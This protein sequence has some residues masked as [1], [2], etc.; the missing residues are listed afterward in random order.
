MFRNYNKF[1][2]M[3]FLLL[4]ILS[5]HSCAKNN[6]KGADTVNSI[7]STKSNPI[8]TTKAPM[9]LSSVTMDKFIGANGF[10]EDNYK[11]M[12]SIGFLRAYCNTDWFTGDNINDLLIFE[13]SRGGWYF[14]EA[15]QKIKDAG[16]SINIVMQECPI[17]L[18][19]NK[20][21][22]SDKPLNSPTDNTT[23]PSSYSGFAKALYQ[24]AARYG[25]TIVANELLR[26]P[27]N[28]KK[29]GLNLVEYIEVWNEPDKG[30]MGPV[31]YFQPEE[32]AAMLSICYDKIKEADPT[33][34]VSMGGLATLGLDYLKR[35]VAWVNKNRPDKRFPAD[36]VNMHIYAFNNKIV[37]GETWPWF[38]PAETPE[39]AGFKTKSKELVD[40]C[41]INIPD[42]EIWISEFG[43][44][45]N[46]NSVL[47][48]KKMDGLTAN[49]IQGRWLIRA[50]LEFAAAGID[51]AQMFALY[52][53]SQN[54]IDTWF[55]TS[56]LCDRTLKFEK[57]TSWYY[58]H[59]LKNTLNNM[60]FIG[61]YPSQNSKILIY[62][63]KDKSAK[64]GVYVLWSNSSN[65]T[66]INNYNLKVN[67]AT[68]AE[69]VEL[70]DK[71]IL[72][73]SSILN[74]T[75]SGVNINVSEKP[76]FVIVDAI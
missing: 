32:Y 62:K 44:D 37:F 11:D 61:E 25:R 36:V 33:M 55:G 69:L 70:I 4:I 10:H 24:M 20:D 26:V 56:G 39:D 23:T 22:S 12:A 1:T 16:V 19:T 7:D 43:W 58:T 29:S 50:Y 14:D 66:I 68:K 42:A 67:K 64:N 59:T 21:G 53:P 71:D 40:Y 47:C 9:P 27:D 41:K 28:Q 3:L 15:F 13:N 60:Q 74:I 63:F 2:K 51:R 72:G 6:N 46:P 49:E 35:M 65:N 18:R 52:D 57:K 54:Y 48:P 34:K 5:A 31:A 73:K 17:G 38:G 76:V 75:N 45:T 8:D 30:W